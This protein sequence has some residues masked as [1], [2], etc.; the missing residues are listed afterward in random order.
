MLR[1]MREK[2]K[3][4]SWTLW[5]VI[6]TFIVGFSMSDFFAKKDPTMSDLLTVGEESIRRDKYEQQLYLT[7][8]NYNAQFQNKLTQATI[9]QLRIPEQVLQ[10]LISSSIV[11]QEAQRMNLSVSDEEL[12]RQITE[13]PSFQQNGRFIGRDNYK[14]LLEMRRIRIVDFEENFRRDILLDKLKELITAGITIDEESLREVFKQQNDQVE[15]D[16]ITLTPESIQEEFSHSSEEIE[17][18]YTEHKDKYKSPE[19]RSGR[20]VFVP[21]EA[22]KPDLK[23]DDNELYQYYRDHKNEYRTPSSRQIRRIFLPYDD[24]NRSATLKEAQSLAPTLT[25]DNFAEQAKGLSKDAKAESGGDW[26]ETEW[27]SLSKQE[28]AIAEKL[29]PNEIST[30]VDNGSGFSIFFAAK[31]VPESTQEFN[32]IKPRIVSVLEREK[33]HRMAAELIGKT[34]KTI[35]EKD[36]LLEKVTDERLQKID[37]QPLA[38]GDPVS[39]TDELGYLSRSLFTLQLGEIK[40]PVELPNGMAIAQLKEI[41]EQAVLPLDQV[42]EQVKSDISLEKKA[43]KLIA[44]AESIIRQLNSASSEKERETLLTTL[45]LKA[46][47]TTYRRGNRFAYYPVKKGL[48][49]MIF[50]LP[51]ERYAQP[52][53]LG[54]AVIIP[55]AKK[56]SVSTEEEY[57]TKRKELF[58]EQLSRRRD[59][60]FASYILNQRDRYPIQFN[61]PMFGE[62]R[63]NVLARYK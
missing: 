13:N 12:S 37:S 52:I 4:L 6:I 1:T 40:S 50:S 62:I 28:I 23:L 44:K 16:Y 58:L 42:V 10:N 22:L 20:F 47:Q 54:Q 57:K 21:Y 48:D 27:K 17:A 9:N 11:Y 26:G 51:R 33:L 24:T 53:D 2:F 25:A 3:H 5:L 35:T 7:L 56:I 49:D 43:Q 18:Y 29:Q 38:N 60:Y 32:E 46:E 14:R 61:E 63:K 41:N 15:L 39:G 59:D 55:R 36:N 8:E 31:V 45:E 30:P 19:K 34:A